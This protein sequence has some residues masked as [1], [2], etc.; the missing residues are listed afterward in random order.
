MIDYD[1]DWMYSLSW[2]YDRF[3]KL[4]S[5]SVWRCRCPICGDSKKNKRLARF[6]FY[7]HT[8]KLMTKCHNC[9]HSSSF[10]NFVKINHEEQFEEYSKK[11]KLARLE[12]RVSRTFKK[13]RVVESAKDEARTVSKLA[14]CIPITQLEASHRA[15]KYLAGRGLDRFSDRFLYSENFKVTAQSLS[16]EPLAEGFAEEPRIVIPFY[17]EDGSISLIQGRSL[18]PKSKMKYITIKSSENAEKTYGLDRLDRS[19]TVY[20]VEGPMDSMFI[21]NSIAVCDANLT[22]VEADVYIWD[23]Q[24][25][26]KEVV[27]YM[28]S[29][30]DEGK[31][32]VIWPFSIDDKLDINDMILKGMTIQQLKKVI[33]KHTY[34]GLMAIAKLNQWK[35]VKND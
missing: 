7:V 11:Y 13:Q 34:K 25:R 1:I 32:V 12:Q 27:N 28:K 23:C 17:L 22:R 33:D 29:A 4:G 30:I 16:E 18:D 26:N 15:V 5:K 6:F 9:N 20:C 2:N 14:G 8:G 31:S 19:K 21:D 10:Y 24:P 35:K 3:T